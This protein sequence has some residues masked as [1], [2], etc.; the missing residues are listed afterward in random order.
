MNLKQ[1]RYFVAI[2][3]QRSFLQAAQVLHISQ[4]SVS[5]Q[6]KLLEEELGVQLFERRFDG[7]IL[8]P[9]GRD[10]LVHARTVLDA[11][12]AAASSMRVHQ[13]SEVGRVAVGIPG[14]LTSLLTVPLIQTVR[15]EMPNV[16]LRVVS[17]LSGHI[18]RWLPE[19]AIDFGLVYASSSAPGLDLEWVLDENLFLA[20][21]DRCDLDGLLE[22][23]GQVPASRL[24][25]LPMVLPGREH[26]LRSVVEGALD[27]VGVSLHVTAEVDATEQLK[28]MVRRT[29]CFTILSLAAIQNDPAEGRLVTARI[30]KP[31]IDRRISI[32]HTT[33]RPLSRAARR[34]KEILKTLIAQELEKGWWTD[35]RRSDGS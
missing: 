16:Q 12:V 35:G 15:Q 17:G 28:E 33:G 27:K 4:P 25:G 31:T 32:A 30:V 29:G 24:A 13:S 10:F 34:V 3:E 2:S 18:A 11:V 20:A 6:I 9:E 21:R 1:F 8:T 14:S 26:G 22:A 23:K 5:A 7:A 19:G